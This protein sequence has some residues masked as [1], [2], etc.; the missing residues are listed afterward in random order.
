MWIYLLNTTAI[1]LL[2]MA[3]YKIW[4]QNE[5][6][7]GYN[8]LYLLASLIMG[9]CLPA[10]EWQHKIT[11]I[12]A[13]LLSPASSINNTT[14]K[15]LSATQATTSAPINYTHWLLIVYISGV[16]L[17]CI[18][19]LIEVVKLIKYYKHGNKI[20]T[21]GW[22]LIETYQMHAPFS[23]MGLLFVGSRN[24]YNNKEWEMILAH[25][26]LHRNLLHTADL[27]LVEITKI[28]FWFH[29]MVYVYSNS[30]LLVH[31]YQADNISVQHKSVYGNFL[32]EQAILHAAP[33]IAHS[34]GKSPIRKR[35]EMMN[36]LPIPR[37]N[38]KLLIAVP[39]MGIS[40]LCFT[41]KT[42][43]DIPVKIGNVCEWRGNKI[44]FK[45]PK[46]PDSYMRR[47]ER[48]GQLVKTPIS[49]PTPALTLN[50]EKIY[51]QGADEQ[52]VAPGAL[53]SDNGLVQYI[54][55]NAKNTIEKLQDG[56]YILLLN[57]VVIDKE[58]KIAYYE[59]NGL[60]NAE[61]ADNFPL[62][63]E[64][65]MAI[66]NLILNAPK[67]SPATKNNLP[68]PYLMTYVYEKVVNREYPYSFTVK[69]H[70]VIADVTAQ[71]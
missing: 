69:N 13:T 26:G 14:N 32:I 57:D 49:W 10:V 19:L 12:S 29:P 62:K 56:N 68:V 60:I 7:H 27:I 59:Y 4:L 38:I 18:R 65:E 66:V 21:D 37:A 45:A 54:H 71:N 2:C 63:E 55:K 43:T 23:F 61:L 44:R 70:K 5:T 53:H 11:P 41:K 52:V 64:T 67:Y 42:E 3:V 40:F 15:A 39:V 24:E 33:T 22:L 34:L 16:V 35:I 17:M 48:S 1:W 46:K 36:R 25:E 20:H 9:T 6:F 47:D 30:L 50:G 58:G 28:I 8:R 31:E 51:E